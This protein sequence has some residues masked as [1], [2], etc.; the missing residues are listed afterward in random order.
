MMKDSIGIDVSK[1]HL[2][3]YC[4]GDRRAARFGNDAAGFRKFKA[5][6]PQTNG[7]AR[8]V[9]EATGPYHA[10]LERRFGGE[11]PLVK[12]LPLRKQG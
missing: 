12:G 2:D 9:Y 4:L 10:G 6:L 5:W 1:D 8:V 11:L 7:I 3:V